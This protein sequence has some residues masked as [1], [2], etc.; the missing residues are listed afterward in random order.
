MT[1]E[2]KQKSPAHKLMV[3]V[4][5]SPP[6][7]FSDYICAAIIEFMGVFIEVKKKKVKSAEKLAVVAL[8]DKSADG[9]EFYKVFLNT[10]LTVEKEEII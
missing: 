2:K 7:N 6:E 3:T 8:F 4:T 5:Y 10:N 9:E 1:Q